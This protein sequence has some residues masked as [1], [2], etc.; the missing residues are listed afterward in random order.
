[1]NHKVA[2]WDESH[3][4]E[5][6]I[7]CVGGPPCLGGSEPWAIGQGLD[8]NHLS[9]HMQLPMKPPPPRGS[10]SGP[11]WRVQVGVRGGGAQVFGAANPRGMMGYAVGR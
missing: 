4:G 1:V 11:E 9:V 8:A 5:G 2:G 7:H 3:W 6:S 10:D